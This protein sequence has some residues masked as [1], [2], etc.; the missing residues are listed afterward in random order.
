MGEGG[1][2]E[3]T[4]VGQQILQEKTTGKYGVVQAMWNKKL[5]KEACGMEIFLSSHRGRRLEGSFL[6]CGYVGDWFF[7]ST[8][9]AKWL[10]VSSLFLMHKLRKRESK[11]KQ[12][13]QHL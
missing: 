2:G 9:V 7:Q 1:R 10:R 13:E 11:Q 3:A 5:H 4:R 8:L 6:P 12:R